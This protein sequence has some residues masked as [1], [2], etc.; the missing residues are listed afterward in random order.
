LKRVAV[1]SVALAVT[2]TGCS[3]ALPPVSARVQAAAEQAG[4]ATA[5]P[6]PDTN[7]VVVV[8]DTYVYGSHMGGQ[9]IN[10]WTYIAESHLQDDLTTD[11]TNAGVAG[12]GYIHRGPQNQ[13]F[14]EVLPMAVGPKTD[15]VV[16]FGSRND[17]GV[18][19]AEIGAT[20]TE[21][22]AQVKRL[23]PKAK[24]IVIGPAWIEENVPT[25]VFEI[26][27]AV[28]SAAS[29]A[30][31]DWVDPLAERWFFDNPSLIATNGILPN[32]KGH[33]YLEKLILPHLKRALGR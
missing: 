1:T 25:D 22:Y 13:T 3:H 7:Q 4:H 31:A 9:S 5:K 23:A 10:N 21:D 24:M 27:D 2:L 28:K 20:A 26:R 17:R 29:K 18:N 8:G 32:D 11:V 15:V 19:P 33:A 30:G 6:E 12:A 14:G 16:F